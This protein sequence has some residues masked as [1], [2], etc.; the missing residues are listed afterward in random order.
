VGV[1]HDDDEV[2]TIGEPLNDGLREGGREGGREGCEFGGVGRDEV[3]DW[4]M[5][6]GGREGGYVLCEW[7]IYSMI[8]HLLVY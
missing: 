5:A 1:E 4:M 7:F 2:G 8:C 3:G 6:W